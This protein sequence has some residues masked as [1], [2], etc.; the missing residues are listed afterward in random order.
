MAERGTCLVTYVP[1]RS[2]PRPG[3]EMVS[4][5]LFGESYSILAK[6]DDFLQILTDFDGY[7][8][9]ISQGSHSPY[10]EGFT[11]VN[12]FIFLEASASH[13]I[14]FIPCAGM[15]PETGKFEMNGSVFT[16]ERKL[17]T[18]SHLPLK[19]RLQRLALTFMNMPYLWGGRSFMGIDC[20][21]F[22]QSVFKANGIHIPRDS[23]QQLLC[24]KEIDF[25]DRQPCDLV[26]LSK[27]DS[28]SV[29]HVGMMLEKGLLIHASGK[30][31]TDHLD[32]MFLNMDG[33][34]CYR[35]VAVKR[36]L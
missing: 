28:D 30:V 5:L 34:P 24:G 6:A 27:P 9:W 36:I 8:G 23:S 25:N 10:K 3:A 11:L 20:S 21:G 4:S 15:L 32:S 7:T 31:R 35:V 26:F 33:K 2:E 16:V 12:E 18:N 1:M 13:Q 17:K 19:L 29:T 14:M 22:V